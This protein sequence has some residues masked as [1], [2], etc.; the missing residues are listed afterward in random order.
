VTEIQA[1]NKNT[2]SEARIR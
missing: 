1:E 2:P